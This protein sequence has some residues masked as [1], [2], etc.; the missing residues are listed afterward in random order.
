MKS[1]SDN[2]PDQILNIQGNV[3]IN[4]NVVESEG[5][6]K[7]D[8]VTVTNDAT[9]NEI[10]SAIIR[11]RYTADDEIA[12]INNLNKGDEK[13]VNEYNDYQDYRIFAK[14]LADQVF[15]KINT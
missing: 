12:L 5:S 7:Y 6:F 14:N 4:V 8:Q 9:R 10:V 3:L 13:Y 2:I 11:S 1:Y 15:T